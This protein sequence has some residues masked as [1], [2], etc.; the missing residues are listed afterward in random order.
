[1]IWVVRHFQCVFSDRCRL[2]YDEYSQSRVDVR[3]STPVFVS[4]S[5]RPMSVVGVS[6]LVI[7]VVIAKPTPRRSWLSARQVKEFLIVLF[8]CE[9]NDVNIFSGVNVFRSHSSI[10][11]LMVTF[12]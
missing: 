9:E 5:S 1:M 7:C 8:Q 3:R 2:D 6:G 12:F 10:T 4:S 11:Y